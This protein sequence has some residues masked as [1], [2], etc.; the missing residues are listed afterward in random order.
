MADWTWYPPP[1]RAFDSFPLN[2]S[3]LIP[4]YSYF[5]MCYPNAPIDVDRGTMVEY[6]QDSVIH[7]SHLGVTVWGCVHETLVEIDVYSAEN[8]MEFDEE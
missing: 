8:E 6:V 4:H 1:R 2:M 7:P 3:I 5:K